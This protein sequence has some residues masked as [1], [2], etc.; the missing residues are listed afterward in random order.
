MTLNV[1]ESKSQIKIHSDNWI[2]I[3]SLSKG[4]GI[5]VQPNGFTTF[6]PAVYNSWGWMNMTIAPTTTSKCYIVK[7]SGVENFFVTGNG[8]MYYRS[9]QQL[10]DVSV[11]T[12]ISKIDNPLDKVLN[13]NGIEYHFIDY[14]DEIE[15]AK[16]F[17]I[18]KDN[19]DILITKE[20]MLEDAHKKEIGFIAQEVE[21]V[22][23]ELVRTLPDGKKSV[24]YV[25]MVGLLVE[26]IKE[27]NEKI[28]NLE[29]EVAELKENTTTSLKQNSTNTGLSK[30][31]QNSPNPFSNITEISYYIDK[32]YDLVK[33]K[34]FNMNGTMMDM[35]NV[36]NFKGVNRFNLNAGHYDQG[37]YIYTLEIDGQDI[38]SKIMILTK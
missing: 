16:K 11:K 21:E 7:K 13:L 27:Q 4:G 37:T 25:N 15:E 36:E 24:S 30:L 12:N 26:A 29:K 6:Q 2:S 20:Q 3:G 34:I 19:S 10:S 31:Y 14:E 8:K 35:Y 28:V 33:I 23:P 38:D 17:T 1:I 32:N 9:T 5:Q 22:V 18:P